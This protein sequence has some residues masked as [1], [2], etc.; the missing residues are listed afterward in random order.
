[1]LTVHALRKYRDELTADLLEFFNLNLLDFERGR[2]SLYTIYCCVKSLMRKPG[3]STLLM[4][5]DPSNE[6]SPDTYIAARV[7]DAMEL[8][9][10]LFLKANTEEDIPVP[11]PI[12]RP[13]EPAYPATPPATDFASGQEVTAFIAKIN[14]L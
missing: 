6:W 1:M 2:L 3:R 8:S 14:N 7:S 12:K 11:E 13:G 4:A 9:N 10:Y 5:L